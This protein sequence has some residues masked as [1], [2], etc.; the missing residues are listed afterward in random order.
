MTQTEVFL[1]ERTTSS[2]RARAFRR[3]QRKWFNGVQLNDVRAPCTVHVLR[4]VRFACRSESG[5]AAETGGV[6]KDRLPRRRQTRNHFRV[7]GRLAAS[8]GVTRIFDLGMSSVLSARCQP[9]PVG[10]LSS[11]CLVELSWLVGRRKSLQPA[12]KSVDDVTT[13]KM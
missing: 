1:F 6:L 12:Y 11:M 3:T 2:T 5:A 7:F 10:L 8:T 4:T 9:Q 13:R